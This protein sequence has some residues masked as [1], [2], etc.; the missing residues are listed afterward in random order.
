MVPSR[1]PLAVAAVAL[2][3]ATA[4]LVLAI[5]AVTVLDDDAT[6]SPAAAVSAATG[7]AYSR[8]RTA[9][10]SRGVS[11][12]TAQRTCLG[13]SVAGCVATI[14]ATGAAGGPIGTLTAAPICR[15]IFS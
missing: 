12:R 11:S 3:A 7:G 4:A 8:C 1:L 5:L 13:V 2:L 10:E 15:F 14:G 6:A 9:L